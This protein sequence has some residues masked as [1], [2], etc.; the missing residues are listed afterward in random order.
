MALGVIGT[1]HRAQ[2]GPIDDMQTTIS[3]ASAGWL[4]NGL[5][6]ADGLFTVL[7][8]CSFVVAIVGEL[9]QEHSL[10]SVGKRLIWLLGRVVAIPWL[11]LQAAHSFLPTIVPF[12]TGLAGRITGESISG[13]GALISI[14]A[15]ITSR[16]FAAAGTPFRAFEAHPSLGGAGSVVGGVLQF[17]PA[18]IIG[19]GIFVCFM[20]LAGELL[21]AFVDA[22][23]KIAI[24]SIQLGWMGA[25]GTKN[26]AEAYWAEVMACVFRIVII[27]SLCALIA[28]AAKGWDTA[29][30]TI[31]DPKLLVQSWL[32]TFGC[33][34]IIA[35]MTTRV[36]SYASNL[37]T[38]RPT[39]SAGE[40]IAATNRA[41]SSGIRAVSR[42]MRGTGT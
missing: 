30:E 6:L 24:G 20:V 23:L 17:F 28:V 22:Y 34:G 35:F 29:L 14:G 33:A 26:F 12:S 9:V 38:G 11:L 15:Q 31:T 36:T 2:A 5:N 37:F 13:P 21:F 18:L 19:F 40:F 32:N 7:L 25:S 8:M 27:V 4:T 16:I 42:G 3:G 1:I 10:H 39:L 41:A